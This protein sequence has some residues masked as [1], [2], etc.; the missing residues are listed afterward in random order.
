MFLLSKKFRLFKHKVQEYLFVLSGVFSKRK[1][2]LFF[3]KIILEN[4]T[5]LITLNLWAGKV[6]EPL[7]IFLKERAKDTDIFCFQEVLFG[8]QGEFTQINQARINIFS[9][10]KNVLPEFVPSVYHAP[11]DAIFFC[12]ELLPSGVRPGQAIFVKNTL[13]IFDQGG[14]RTY[15][16]G[17]IPKDADRGGRV[18]GNCQWVSV[19][20]KKGDQYTI[21]NIHGLHQRETKKADTPERLTQSRMLKDFLSSKKEKKILCGDFNLRP[22]DESIKILEQDMR[23]LVR[24]FCIASTRSSWYTK[25]EKFADYVFTSP[26]TKINYF[27]VLPDEVSDHLALAL[28]FT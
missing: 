25:P 22:D 20:D 28:D 27:A 21:L 19:Q 5:K 11:E 2:P 26:D 16:D 13:K 8:E 6:Y 10:I 23:N 7:M 15:P 12:D 3:T 9:E 17:T 18:T 1:S 4:M 14:F 24:E